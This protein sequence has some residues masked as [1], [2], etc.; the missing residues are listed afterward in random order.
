MNNDITIFLMFKIMP[1]EF[2]D[3]FSKGDLYF[4]CCANWIDISKR[5][6][7]NGQGD[8][9]E[10]VFAK[11]LRKN[12]R[13]PIKEYKKAFKKDLIVET[14]GEYKLLKRRSSLYTP[15][16]CFYSYDSNSIMAYIPS[17]DK[18]RIDK[19]FERNQNKKEF[20]IENFP[21]GISD[22]Y[23][24]DFNID[25]DNIDA[26]TIQ[27]RNMILKLQSE[28][29][30]C[31]PVKYIDMDGEFDIFKE[32]HYKSFEGNLKTAFD[33]HVEI[34]FKDKKKYSHQCEY[35]VVMPGKLLSGMKRGK[36]VH[37]KGL[38]YISAPCDQ[39]KNVDAINATGKDIIS[40]TKDANNLYAS[41]T[42]QK[43]ANQ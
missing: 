35:R 37:V 10:G 20:V 30:Y 13:K 29:A 15:A 38:S 2:I 7:N 14:D 31:H 8:R 41:I 43:K 4:S 5:N 24:K 27:P 39:S 3:S 36:I 18:D 25:S 21:L 33:K 11:Y 23:L 6:T 9:Y 1:K 12:S 22:K 19:A 28:G 34:F 17:K 26:V 42:F 40:N 32:K 16:M